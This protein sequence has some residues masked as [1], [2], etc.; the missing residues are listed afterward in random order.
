MLALHALF[1]SN[2][3]LFIWGEDSAKWQTALAKRSRPSTKKAPPAHPFAASAGQISRTL[4]AEG[5]NTGVVGLSNSSVVLNL[6]T[7]KLP[8]KS[9]S[10]L[11]EDYRQA[12]DNIGLAMWLVEGVQWSNHSGH[13]LIGAFDD[14]SSPGI[15]LGDTFGYWL[16]ALRLVQ[17][18]VAR[19]RVLPTITMENGKP[20]ARW[21]LHA[22]EDDDF[23]RRRLLGDAMPPICQAE[24][25]D[26]AGE[27][28]PR[29]I[30][31]AFLT[32]SADTMCRQLLASV[33]FAPLPKAKSSA[34]PPAETAFMEA[35]AREN[36]AIRAT[37]R[38][39]QRLSDG[40]ALWSK[41]ISDVDQGAL[42][43]TF[44]LEA[45][46][47]AGADQTGSSA[48][49]GSWQLRF[50]LQAV[51]D[52]SLQIPAEDVWRSRGAITRFLKQ[53]Y[54]HPQER[55]LGDLGRATRLCPLI[56]EG[57]KNARPGGAVLTAAQAYD[58][59]RH[60]AP[61]LEQA[62]F[63]VLVPQWWKKPAHL[64]VRLKVKGRD[65]G[66]ATSSGLLGLQGLVD[67][68][69]EIAIGDKAIAPAEF[70]KLA[71][72]KVPLVKVRGQWVELNPDQIEAAIAF[73]SRQKAVG[74]MTLAEAIRLNSGLE[75]IAGLPVI[76]MSTEGWL[77][78]LVGEGENDGYKELIAAPNLFKGELRPYQKRG[79]SWLAFLGQRG[80]GAC[81][82]DD[83]GLGKTIQLIALLLREREEAVSRPGPTLLVCP[84]SVIG[85]WQREVRKFAPS[86]STLLHH[87][88]ERLGE[89]DFISEAQTRDL[90]ITSYAVA[91]RDVAILK[92]LRWKRVVLD[93]AQNIKNSQTKQSQAVR[94][95]TSDERVA[96]TGTPV[97]NRLSEL[98]SI[99]EFL[100]P[101]YLGGPAEFR[102]RFLIPIERY[103][104]EA[105]ATALK[106]LVQ[107]FVLRRLKTDRTIIVDL[108]DKIDHR[109]FC[110]LTREQASLYQAVVDEMLE[111]IKN[112]EGINRKGLVLA[113]MLRLKQVC[114]HP[115]HF[116]QDHSS[117]AERSGKLERLTEMLEEVIEV[118]DKALVFTQFAEMGQMLKGYLQEYFG[119]EV[120]FLHGGTPRK[121]RDVMVAN[122]QSAGPAPRIFILSL[123]AGG[124]GLNLTGANHVFHFDRWWNPAVENQATDRAFRIGQTKNVQVHK[125]V[126]Q[127]TLEERIDAMI[128]QKKELAEKIMGAGET[129]LTELSTTEL[130]DLISLGS[131]AVGETD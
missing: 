93:E 1:L 97:E 65:A 5:L 45:P 10:L 79:L 39:V 16:K 44:R 91:T 35:L 130:R 123:K 87:G 40:L 25:I 38:D 29:A 51:G 68:S 54:E 80:L 17:E 52:K 46:D 112:S 85:N 69:W 92:Q 15:I 47:E 36:P 128:E 4:T 75:P 48:E 19:G 57:L 41:G 76:N 70:A 74:T 124:V 9:P 99:M 113:T 60:G 23:A 63:G 14:F 131:D 77:S 84:M 32:T 107:P 56:E 55:L 103:Q 125:Y 89:L 82:A 50:L 13:D 120:L 115:A 71:A 104:N 49:N 101:G 11:T 121:T 18:W 105:R 126:C 100:N 83:M 12:G 7:D 24:V 53:N 118:G 114:N 26:G 21:N 37:A 78:K 72:L 2:N 109:V 96:M 102:Q 111:K 27:P 58:F 3:N 117:L 34:K 61:L 42:R 81:L 94:Q 64:G 66:S 98:W 110:N 73:F 116:L 119:Q 122:F 67:Y 59:L 8:V 31:D 129:W 43:T 33:G 30:L 22:D 90:V 108:P 62:G 28:D 106:R 127:G 6:P 86:L 20:N 95:L 88:G